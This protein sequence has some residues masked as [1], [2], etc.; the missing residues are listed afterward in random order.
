MDGPHHQGIRGQG[1][2]FSQAIGELHSYSRRCCL[3]YSNRGLLRFTI[4]KMHWGISLSWGFIDYFEQQNGKTRLARTRQ[5]IRYRA[6][7]TLRRPKIS[8]KQKLNKSKQRPSCL[9]SNNHDTSQKV[10][11][12]VVRKESEAFYTA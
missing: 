4:T 3:P 2:R 1:L 5:I 10:C 8:N 11:H 7:A 6:T 12:I 9:G